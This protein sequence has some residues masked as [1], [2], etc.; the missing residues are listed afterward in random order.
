MWLRETADGL[1]I[2]IDGVMKEIEH[3]RVNASKR[4]KKVKEDQPSFDIREEDDNVILKAGGKYFKMITV[5]KSSNIEDLLKEDYERKLNLE[6]ERI[7][8]ECKASVDEFKQYAEHALS[9]GQEEIRVLRDRLRNSAIMPEINFEHAKLGLSV[10]K[11]GSGQLIW[12]YRTVFNPVTL[13]GEPLDQN[14]IKKMISP[15]IIMIVTEQNKVVM[16]ETKTLT[17]ERFRH[18]HR[19]GSANN[20]T[21][22]SD[23]WGAWKPSGKTWETADDIIKIARE[24]ANVLSNINSHSLATHA[25][26]G[27]PRVSTV[28][29]HIIRY[30]IEDSRPVV[31]DLVLNPRQERAGLRE[32][33]EINTGWTVRR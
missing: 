12:L 25:P 9:E 15:M 21:P 3:R 27:L 16:T 13:D 10:T 26:K 29:D 6:K 18:Y 20:R 1:E 33:A 14:I 30:S 4:L 19:H 5:Q 7:L 32:M 22:G 23:C 17:L 11:G 2:D 8:A 31:P 24:A 28:R